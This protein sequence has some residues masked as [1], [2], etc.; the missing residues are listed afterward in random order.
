M[1][2]SRSKAEYIVGLARAVA[3]GELDL[4][5]LS[6]ISEA[7]RIERLVR[8][9]GIGRWTAEYGS[10]RG[11]GARDSLPAADIGLRNAVTVAY[12]L[13]HQA[14]EA[15]VRAM[16]ERWT[17]WRAFATFYLWATLWSL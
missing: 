13:D 10:M 16:G 7:E 5:A 14:T 9:R 1:Q 8:L 15:E 3:S 17:P 6:T 11:Y 4:D 2:F 12:R